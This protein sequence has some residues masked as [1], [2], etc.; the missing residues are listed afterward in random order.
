MYGLVLDFNN[1]WDQKDLKN[2]M[3]EL[4]VVCRKESGNSYHLESIDM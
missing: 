3:I 4:S 1:A 2:I